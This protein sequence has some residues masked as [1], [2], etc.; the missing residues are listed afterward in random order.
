VKKLLPIGIV[1]ALALTVA[2]IPAT[3]RPSDERNIV[4]TAQAAGN[5]KTLTK[6]VVKAGLAGTLSSSGPYTVFAP[7]DAAFSKVPKST[8]KALAKNRAKLRAVLLY[9]VVAG[10]VPS[11]QVVMLKSAK[12]LNGK[13]VRIHTAGGKVFVNNAKVTK[14]DINASNGVIHVVNRVLIPPAH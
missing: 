2:G 8:L 13:S 11:S 5:F 6:L 10:R 1:A 14:A 9:H 4:Q 12:T 7:T 3:A